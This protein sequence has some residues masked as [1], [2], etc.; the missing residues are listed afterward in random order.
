MINRST[1]STAVSAT[2][3]PA[4][5]SPDTSNVHSSGRHAASGTPYAPVGAGVPLSLTL[6]TVGGLFRPRPANGTATDEAGSNAEVPA[7]VRA[8][9]FVTGEYSPPR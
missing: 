8:D 2:R 7:N 9:D 4:H 3:V 1:S 6:V 5:T